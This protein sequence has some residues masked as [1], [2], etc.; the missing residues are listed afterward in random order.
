MKTSLKMLA[1]GAGLIVS[2]AAVSSAQAQG[3]AAR[4]RP[5][6]HDRARVRE[7][8]SEVR[9]RLSAMTPQQRE[10]Y[11]AYEKAYLAE[12]RQ[13]R[14][15]LEAGTMTKET[16]AEQLKAWRKAHRPPTP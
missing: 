6:A 14:S 1:F 12:R 3:T 4:T 13:L 15:Q 5:L 11:R 7:H 8:Q 10:A 9:T 16:A 2:A